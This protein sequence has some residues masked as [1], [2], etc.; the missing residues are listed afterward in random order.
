MRKRIKDRIALL[1]AIK[2]TER[3]TELDHI[4]AKVSRDAEGV[5]KAEIRDAL[6]ELREEHLVETA[7]GG[8][9]ITS[10][11]R[12]SA[13]PLTNDPNM[14]LS[15]RRVLTARRY[16]SQTAPCILPFLR[17]NI[18]AVIKLF[19]NEGD[20]IN[21]VKEIFS[22]FSKRKPPQPHTIEDKKT[23]IRYVHNHTVEFLLVVNEKDVKPHKLV[24]LISSQQLREPKEWEF[25]LN[26]VRATYEEMNTRGISPLITFSG[27][28]GFNIFCEFTEPLGNWKT[29]Q[30]AVKTLKEKVERILNSRGELAFPLLFASSRKSENVEGVVFNAESM[31]PNGT[32]IA[33]FSLN[34]TTGLASIPVKPERIGHF[35]KE[36]AEPTTVIKKKKQYE[37]F[38]MEKSSPTTFAKE[39]SLGLFKFLTKGGT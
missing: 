31:R 7:E 2:P 32:V 13:R 4:H 33:P 14:N 39:L 24:F 25:L 38:K 17:G 3:I 12:K 5:S 22:R 9:Y 37:T 34:L 16:Y 29:Y 36:D 10:Q 8:W 30:H 11:G 21:K 28:S 27:E 35:K 18:L 6:R 26:V 20:P 23:L 1:L 19:S 15:Y